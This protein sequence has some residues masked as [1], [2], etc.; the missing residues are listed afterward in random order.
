MLSPDE[1]REL[2]LH[3]N[4]VRQNIIRMLKEAGSGHSGGPLG[5][6]DVFTALYFKVLNVD[7]ANP[8][9][10]DRDRL[11]L[12]NGHIC[13][14]M[15]ATMAERGFFPVEELMTLRKFGSRLQGHPHRT[16]LPG[17]ETTSGPLGSGLSQAAGMALA[18]KM[19]KKKQRVFCLTS[20]GE[21]DEG[22]IWEA[23][24]FAGRYKL[25][26]LT[27]FM[28]RNKIQIDGNTEDVMPLDPVI[29]KYRAFNWHVIEID[30]HDF[31]QILEAV[32]RAENTEDRPTMIVARTTP[33]KGVSY[34]EHRYEW[35]GAPPDLQDMEGAPPKGEQAKVAIEELEKIRR[36]WQGD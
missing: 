33:G 13:P 11:I 7:P 31:K 1:I 34:M 2:S 22:N 10:E 24:L 12:S 18:F 26:N 28:D 17:L 14:V 3:A 36:D 8:D 20:D 21:H 32:K 27:V 15:Y 29:D 9:K 25:N 35:H 16:A 5:M 30:G 19:D 23:V 4:S 6:A